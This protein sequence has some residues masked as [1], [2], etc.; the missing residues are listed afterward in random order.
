MTKES[1]NTVKEM[2]GK[3]PPRS[4]QETTL[5]LLI[6]WPDSIKYLYSKYQIT[7]YKGETFPFEY[8]LLRSVQH[9]VITQQ[10]NGSGC[11]QM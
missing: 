4:Q 2:V 1:F 3:A 8:K 9:S 10:G 11:N 5:L 6:E 7:V